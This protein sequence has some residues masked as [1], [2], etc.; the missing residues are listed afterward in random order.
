MKMCSG[1]SVGNLGANL[2]AAAVVYEHTA[3]CLRDFASNQVFGMKRFAT[4]AL[5]KSRTLFVQLHGMLL[6]RPDDPGQGFLLNA[7][8]CSG[9]C[10]S[11][12]SSRCKE[13]HSHRASSTWKISGAFIPTVERA[14]TQASIQKY[15][16]K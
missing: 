14:R 11:L 8:S 15:I 6:E 16:K 12:Q 3:R 7:V 13:C 10:H 5:A 9:N 4:S 2:T 1:V